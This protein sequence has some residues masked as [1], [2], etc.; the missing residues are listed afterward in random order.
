MHWP[1][2]F[3]GLNRDPV[4]DFRMSHV[5]TSRNKLLLFASEWT[6]LIAM[7]E[8]KL[9]YVLAAQRGQLMLEILRLGGIA[10]VSL[11]AIV[12]RRKTNYIER[13]KERHWTYV[14]EEQTKKGEIH[15][16]LA[17]GQN[18]SPII[19]CSF[20]HIHGSRH[21]FIL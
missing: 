19:I 18:K 13:T 6:I 15:M 3:N 8:N 10:E 21:I 5:Q 14:Y 2:W 11:C 20:K 9:F 4:R 7:T 17:T 16:W 1:R 12:W